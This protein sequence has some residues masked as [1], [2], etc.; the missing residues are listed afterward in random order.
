M[1]EG[2]RTVATTAYL[3]FA[4]IA[5]LAMAT[6]DAARADIRCDITDQRNNVVSYTFTGTPDD[7]QAVAEASYSRNGTA[8]MNDKMNP[9]LWSFVIDNDKHTVSLWSRV[10]QGWAIVSYVNPSPNVGGA[11][12]FHN[13][14]VVGTGRCIR[15]DDE[16]RPQT[17]PIV[18]PFIMKG[19][20]IYVNVQVGDTTITMLLD[21]GANLV[22]INESL[23]NSLIASGQATESAPSEAILADGSK[24][25]HRSVLVKSLW[26]GSHQRL[27]V[28]VGVLPDGTEPLLGLPVLNAIGK[29]TIDSANRQLIFG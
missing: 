18:V 4:L 20:G 24:Q 10:D 8:T 3:R 25:A 5:S 19:G 11:T 17:P 15:I 13:N 23:A 16:P 29:F 27:N 12:L 2:T 22:T 28:L 14:N 21:T 9:R 26:V 6:A 1:T 7:K